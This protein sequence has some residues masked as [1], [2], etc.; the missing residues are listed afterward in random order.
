[1]LRMEWTM[2]LCT[3]LVEFLPGVAYP[4]SPAPTMQAAESP[5][6]IPFKLYDGHLIIVKGTIGS[7]ANVNIILDT[8]KSP[9]AVSE[10][11]AK[12]LNLRGNRDSMLLSNGK[13][14]VQSAVLTSIRIGSV[15][16][17]GVRVVEQDL[18]FMERRLGISIA[19]I[20]GI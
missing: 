5:A 13:I 19:G 3:A 18:S 6:E 10:A 4:R 20:A 1:M 7:L 16:A 12:K 14:E 15:S 2:T 9:T 8:G 17:E 11:V